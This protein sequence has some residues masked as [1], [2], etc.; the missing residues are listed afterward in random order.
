MMAICVILE[1]EALAAGRL[2]MAVSVRL[3]PYYYYFSVPV[4]VAV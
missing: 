4:L 1:E 3:P 2:Q